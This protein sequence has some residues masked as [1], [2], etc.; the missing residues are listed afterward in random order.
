MA[1]FGER[2]AESEARRVGR[3]KSRAVWVKGLQEGDE[4]STRSRLKV[5]SKEVKVYRKEAKRSTG[6]S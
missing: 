1:E 2:L 4:R 6:R 3:H 5:Y